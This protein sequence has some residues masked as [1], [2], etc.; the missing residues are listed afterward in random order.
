MFVCLATVAHATDSNKLK[1]ESTSYNVQQ[2]IFL[3]QAILHIAVIPQHPMGGSGTPKLA[4]GQLLAIQ[5]VCLVF[6]VQAHRYLY[7]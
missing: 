7:V 1:T 2:S 5:A 3:S 6:P 4:W